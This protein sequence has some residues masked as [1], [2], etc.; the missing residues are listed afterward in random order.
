MVVVETISAVMAL[1]K[2]VDVVAQGVD[3]ANSAKSLFR[4]VDSIIR[5]RE[6]ADQDQENEDLSVEAV[7]EA[8]L[9][10]K[11]TEEKLSRLATKIDI[12][13]GPG[14]WDSILAARQSKITVRDAAI[15]RRVDQKRETHETVIKALK[16]IAAVFVIL[17]VL[18][19]AV[20]TLW[21]L[22]CK[23]GTC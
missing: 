12:R 7:A 21:T 1:A 19:L 14:T 16:E 13:W 4:G 11:K 9:I 5:A 10:R 15:Q 8:V 22:K 20:W 3:G 23:D 6:R 17:S 2:V 18:G